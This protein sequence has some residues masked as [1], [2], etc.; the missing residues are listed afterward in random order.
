MREIIL[1]SV[2]GWSRYL[3]IG[4]L[5]LSVV[6]YVS[7]YLG[8]DLPYPYNLAGLIATLG[9]ASLFATIAGVWGSKW[10]FLGLL[11]PLFNAMVL[12]SLEA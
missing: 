3:G 5:L 1:G 11:G 2:R 7:V 8:I 10:W 12:L 6:L 4:S 9:G